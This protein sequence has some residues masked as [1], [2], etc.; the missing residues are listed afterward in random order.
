[1]G[2]KRVGLARTQAL[3]ENLKRDLSLNA[4]MLKGVKRETIACTNASAT[5]LTA[6]Q[7]GA[8]VVF[9]GGSA[10]TVTLP[11][12]AD[13]LHFEFFARSAQAHVVLAKSAVIQGAIYDNSNTSSDGAVARAAVND[14]MR[15]T[16][17]NAAV[18]D[19]LVLTSDG[20]NWYLHSWLN[21]TA[22]VAGS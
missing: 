9:T 19:R 21:D 4:S 10:A 8:L 14:G 11:A 12:V 15:I 17:A 5:E 16:L 22:T 2:S 3:I 18:G 7:S 1:M 6:E 20:T 13:G